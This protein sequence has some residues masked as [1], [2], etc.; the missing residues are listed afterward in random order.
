MEQT[1]KPRHRL[2]VA[3]AVVVLLA[4][5]G[6]LALYLTGVFSGDPSIVRVQSASRLDRIELA[7][8]DV[9]V[10]RQP[11]YRFLA[12]ELKAPGE[13]FIPTDEQYEPIKRLGPKPQCRYYDAAR[14]H[15]ILPDG[16][17]IRANVIGGNDHGKCD[18]LSTAFSNVHIRP[19]EPT[20]PERLLVVWT[21]RPQDAPPPYK[22]RLDDRAPVDV[23]DP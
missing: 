12:I 10:R 14:F 18:A 3:V 4:G 5:G 13:A 8:G 17:A 23:P 20:A 1:S 9:L 2:K 6:I 11:S 16:R 15:L 21:I 22:L 7:G 19:V